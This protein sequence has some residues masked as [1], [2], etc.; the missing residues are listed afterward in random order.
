MNPKGKDTDP[1]IDEVRSH[2]KG[3]P[4]TFDMT[5]EAFKNNVYESNLSTT[6][7]P[8]AAAGKGMV[9]WAGLFSQT[10][11]SPIPLM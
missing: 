5:A 8:N 6:L 3:I 4:D 2:F 10:H 11:L 1:T 9:L 7:V